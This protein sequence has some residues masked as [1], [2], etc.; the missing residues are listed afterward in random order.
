MAPDNET[1][2]TASSI[3]ATYRWV[4]RHRADSRFDY[5]EYR[6]VELRPDGQVE[7]YWERSYTSGLFDTAEAARSDALDTISWL[8]G[9]LARRTASVSIPPKVAATAFDPFLPLGF[10]PL[11]TLAD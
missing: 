1:V 6:Y 3:E 7:G 5:A 2:E 9:Q 11:R 8:P 10:E 4:L